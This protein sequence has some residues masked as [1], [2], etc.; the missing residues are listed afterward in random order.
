MKAG[1]LRA[2]VA[3]VRHD[4]EASL[5]RGQVGAEQRLCVGAVARVLHDDLLL[6]DFLERDRQ[7]LVAVD[8][9]DQR[10]DELVQALTELVVIRVDLARPPGGEVDERVLAVDFGQQFVDGRDDGSLPGSFK[11]RAGQR[12]RAR[13]D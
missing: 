1:V 13:Q 12:W 9:V 5:F 4:L 2:L 6:R 10:P 8:V 7:R 3:D 11:G